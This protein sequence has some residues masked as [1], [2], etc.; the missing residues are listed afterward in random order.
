[1]T[2]FFS[3]ATLFLSIAVVVIAALQLRVADDKLRLDLFDRRYKV[4]DVTRK[5]LIQ[6]AQYNSFDESE[7]V[8][9]AAG[10]SDAEFPFR[11]DVVEYLKQIRKRALDMRDQQ[12]I[13]EQ[14][15]QDG[16]LSRR[17]NAEWDQRSWLREQITDMASVFTPYLRFANI[18][19][20]PGRVRD[21]L[22]RIY[23]RKSQ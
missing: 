15:L 12:M 6:I 13:L 20:R 8:D 7:L 9:F 19:H 5:F 23:V 17:A 11:A 4:Y 10:I 18:A 1:M 22:Q 16:E 3:I 2:L 21:W 14:E